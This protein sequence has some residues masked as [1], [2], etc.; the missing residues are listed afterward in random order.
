MHMNVPNFPLNQAFL[1]VITLFLY[2]N[3][4]VTIQTTV[5]KSFHFII[6]SSIFLG[7]VQ[8]YQS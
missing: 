2:E 7:I 8:F 3:L 6:S 4:Y 1:N 5:L